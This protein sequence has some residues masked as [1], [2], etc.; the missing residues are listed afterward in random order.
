MATISFRVSDEEKEII[1]NFSKKNNIS[2]SKFVLESILEK[3]EDEE[4]YR[5]GV[6]RMLDPN[7]KIAGDL[8]ELAEECGIDYDAL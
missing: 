2:M 5:L 4:D 3:I 1:S 6:E 7:N 8:R